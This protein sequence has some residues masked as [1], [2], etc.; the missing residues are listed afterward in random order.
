MITIS[1]K[2]EYV[3]TIGYLDAK[4]YVDLNY[5]VKFENK[6]YRKSFKMI[7]YAGGMEEI[8]IIDKLIDNK[9]VPKIMVKSIIKNY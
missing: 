8:G 2:D 5:L 6:L 1:N 3:T 7:D 9:Y 4:N